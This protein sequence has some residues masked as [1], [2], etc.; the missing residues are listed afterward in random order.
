MSKNGSEL[1]EVN[2]LPLNELKRHHGAN[3]DHRKEIEM[4]QLKACPFCGEYPELELRGGYY[5][6]VCKNPLCPS[7]LTASIKAN[8]II[9]AWNTRLKPKKKA[10]GSEE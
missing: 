8:D 10:E 6:I 7:R 2:N 5:R 4:K 9:A 3:K 1:F